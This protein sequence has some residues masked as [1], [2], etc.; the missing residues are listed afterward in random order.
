MQP[1]FS[2]ISPP[3]QGSGAPSPL[4]RALHL[5][6]VHTY[7]KHSAHSSPTIIVL[8]EKVCAVFLT[9]IS[10]VTLNI[11]TV[12]SHGTP[13][14][15]PEWKAHTEAALCGVSGPELSCCQVLCLL[16][17]HSIESNSLTCGKITLTNSS[18]KSVQL[19]NQ[20]CK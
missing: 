4:S 6:N 17:V 2:T 5:V 1:V 13:F 16:G 10:F 12:V 18:E 20:R 11:D 14:P 9:Y 3:E 15:S 19:V 7:K 8:K